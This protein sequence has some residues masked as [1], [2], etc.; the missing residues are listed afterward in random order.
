MEAD[1]MAELIR[2]FDWS[3]T[4]LGPVSSWPQSL[5]TS[6]SLILNSQHPMWIGWGPA[7]LFY[8]TTP[9]SGC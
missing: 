1:E 2:A 4:P 5:R 8:T 9:T 3:Q 6:V 7:C